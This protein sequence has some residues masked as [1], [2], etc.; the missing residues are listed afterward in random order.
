MN[1]LRLPVLSLSLVFIASCGGSD[2]NSGSNQS[3]IGDTCE[4]TTTSD[5]SRGDTDTLPTGACDPGE[6]VCEL[7]VR[8]PCPCIGVQV[9]R[10]FYSCTCDAGT[11]NCVM[12]SQDSG[13]CHA[14]MPNCVQ[15]GGA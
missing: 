7:V 10:K 14:G 13:I 12:T 5:P 15:D 2:D 1:L 11:W 3:T 6:P 9:P 4:H 8:D